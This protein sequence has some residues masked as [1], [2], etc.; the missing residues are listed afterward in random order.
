MTYM[1]HS[2]IIYYYRKRVESLREKLIIVLRVQSIQLQNGIVD[3]KIFNEIITLDAQNRHYEKQINSHKTSRDRIKRD[4]EADKKGNLIT[5][6][7]DDSGIQQD[8]RERIG[9][10]VYSNTKLSVNWGKVFQ[11]FSERSEDNDTFRPKNTSTP[12]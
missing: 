11:L 4:Q 1:E 7:N 10:E 9:D 8:F 5:A 12:G 2:E 3:E 6:S